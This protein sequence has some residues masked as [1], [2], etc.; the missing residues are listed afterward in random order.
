M[1][2]EAVKK[3]LQAQGIMKAATYVLMIASP[4]NFCL[5]YLLVHQLGVGFIGAPLATSFSFWLM[6][7][8]LLAYV[9]WVNGSEAWGG[10]S[11]E[12]FKEWWPFLR[13]AIPGI[14]MVCR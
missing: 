10:W 14:A 9:K 11:A 5:N 3:Y 13:L 6:L 7:I 4:I 8:L 1:A 2:F 12:A